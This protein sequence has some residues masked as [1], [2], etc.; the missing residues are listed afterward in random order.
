VRRDGTPIPGLPKVEPWKCPYHNSRAA[1]NGRA[2]EKARHS[3]WT[4]S[5]RSRGICLLRLRLACPTAPSFQDLTAVSRGICRTAQRLRTGRPSRRSSSE[6]GAVRLP[7]APGR[8]RVARRADA[9]A[10]YIL[11][12]VN[13]SVPTPG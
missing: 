6:C 9:C 3:E 8:P 7:S 2:S 1:S 13:R 4:P 10:V 12:N 5:S 11:S